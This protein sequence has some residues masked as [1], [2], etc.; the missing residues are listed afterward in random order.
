[1]GHVSPGDSIEP[2]RDA[3]TTA[4]ESLSLVIVGSTLVGAILGGLG[5]GLWCDA[6]AGTSPLFLLLGLFAGIGGAA[7][8]LV[9]AGSNRSKSDSRG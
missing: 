4:S 7:A 5:L 8:A 2:A 1:M 6:L 3:G 9:R